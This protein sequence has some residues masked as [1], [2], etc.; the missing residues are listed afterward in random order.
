MPS[1]V[2][3]VRVALISDSL[4]KDEAILRAYDCLRNE[5]IRPIGCELLEPVI[6]L[7]PSERE[8]A[9]AALQAAGLEVKLL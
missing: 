3:V 9:M 4:G 7:A 8:K 1:V 2:R 5:G 6:V